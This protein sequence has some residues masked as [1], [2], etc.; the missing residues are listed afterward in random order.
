M[1]LLTYLRDPDDNLRY[2]AAFAIEAAVKAYPGGM[3]T[4]DIQKLDSEGHR[5]MVAKFVA[6]IEQL[7][8]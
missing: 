1:A 5:T 4:N 8:K 7:P 3:S 6:G 2:V